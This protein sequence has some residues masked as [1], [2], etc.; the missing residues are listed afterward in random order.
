MKIIDFD[1]TKWNQ[2]NGKDIDHE[3]IKVYSNESKD[4]DV[5][6]CPCHCVNF[7]ENFKDV[8]LKKKSKINCKVIEES[9]SAN[10]L[11]LGFIVTKYRKECMEKKRNI[12]VF[13]F[14]FDIQIT[15]RIYIVKMGYLPVDINKTNITAS[16]YIQEH[17][18]SLTDEELAIVD[19]H[20]FPLPCPKLSADMGVEEE[21]NVCMEDVSEFIKTL[22]IILNKGSDPIPP[23]ASLFADC[24]LTNSERIVAM[25]MF[26]MS[27]CK[28]KQAIDVISDSLVTLVLQCDATDCNFCMTKLLAANPYYKGKCRNV[29]SLCLKI[30]ES[31]G[32]I[33]AHFSQLEVWKTVP[34]AV[35]CLYYLLT[36][37]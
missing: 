32:L 35:K 20:V 7:S 37:D 13:V 22:A 29:Y 19:L 10:P 4:N 18:I 16:D 2:G 31:V 36:I 30:R 9:L 6:G 27:A 33:A 5:L 26:I 23:L 15:Q 1:I 11:N 14:L 28:N 21:D 17:M 25:N 8:Q 24:E 3:L 12:C 34:V